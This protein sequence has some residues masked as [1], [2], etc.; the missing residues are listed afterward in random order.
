M[1]NLDIFWP[2]EWPKPCLLGCL[3]RDWYQYLK[4]V[5]FVR[6]TRSPHTQGKFKYLFIFSATLCAT[7][8]HSYRTLQYKHSSYTFNAKGFPAGPGT[9]TALLSVC[10][11]Y[12]HHHV[13]TSCLFSVGKKGLYDYWS[14]PRIINR[15]RLK[16]T[17]GKRAWYMWCDGA[18]ERK[19]NRNVTRFM[20]FCKKKKPRLSNTQWNL[21]SILWFAQK[22]K[23]DALCFHSFSNIPT[24]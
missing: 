18:S 23:R 14:L 4:A 15:F 3:H 16:F 6:H 20:P 13:I 22:N 19:P 21:P 24:V 8:V 12:S 5:L 9:L 1:F 2:F 7:H 11:L 17:E 10:M